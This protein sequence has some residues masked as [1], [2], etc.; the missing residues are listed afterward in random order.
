MKFIIENGLLILI[1]FVS[2][3]LL[4]W[5][6]ILRRTS[7]ALVTHLQATQ[8]M[9]SKNTLL[10]DIRTSD[11]FAR[12]HIT[13]SKN[14]PADQIAGRLSEISKQ[15]NSGLI[16]ADAKGN[17]TAVVAALLKKEGFSEVV[18]LEGGVEGWKNA[19]LPLTK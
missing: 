18:T 1:A 9:N 5:P 16:L 7:G 6:A 3:A 13:G 12:G 19:G 2:G 8:L 4:V 15:K 11:E 14:I 17:K 10:V